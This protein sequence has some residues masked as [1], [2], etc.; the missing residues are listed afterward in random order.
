MTE[1][2]TSQADGSPTPCADRLYRSIYENDSD[3]ILL[4]DQTLRMMAA[5][6]SACLFLGYTEQELVGSPFEAV[7][8]RDSIPRAVGGL[9]AFPKTPGYLDLIR[10]DG[11]SFPAE[12]RIATFRNEGTDI[13][14]VMVRDITDRL[15]AEQELRESENRLRL[16][17]ENATDAICLLNADG[18]IRYH[19]PALERLSGYSAGELSGMVGFDLL[20]P[21]DRD[22]VVKVFTEALKK[23]GTTVSAN[24][25]IRQKDGT[26]RSVEG[27]GI[28]RIDDPAVR[29]FVL[30]VQDV[31]EKQKLEEILLHAQKMKAIGTLAGGVAHEINN[32]LMGIQ[33]YASLIL[34]DMNTADRHYDR[35]LH[36]QKQ[37]ESG[38]NLTQQLLGF[39]RSGRYEVKPTDINA[40][41]KKAAEVFG[42]SKREIRIHEHLATDLWPVEADRGQIEQ[43]LL[44]L[45]INAWQAMP[46]GGQLHLE[47]ANVTLDETSAKAHEISP[48]PYVRISVTDTGVGMDETTKARI[49]EPFFT[50][51]ELGRGKGLG[52]AVAYGIVRGH[53]GII[54]ASSEK[55]RGSVFSIYLPASDQLAVPENAV[56]T[57]GTQGG[58]TIL[59]VDDEPFIIDVT[60]D[61]LKSFGYEVLAAQSGA[62]AIQIYQE[63]AS[64]IGLV[65]LDMIMP[66]MGG[67]DVFERL[68]ITNPHV[69]VI[70]ASGYSISGH[71]QT[72]MER[73]C[74]AFLQKPFSMTEL[75][76]KVRE[77]L[78]QKSEQPAKADPSPRKK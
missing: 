5:N 41:V 23:P 64:S 1:K 57:K 38:A 2:T 31:T 73:G 27:F 59:I 10:K 77:V 68:K 16:L 69:K 7:V 13:T 37:V 26:S 30:N 3:G 36:I 46:S 15:Q 24:C 75:S 49:F 47:T 14:T 18:V 51:R 65:I 72:I 43:V 40:L 42:R 19:N 11:T 45:Y 52:L 33:G 48:G 66:D 55:G 25:R 6:R 71:A 17:F 9:F 56:S 39:A 61:I 29:G 74:S 63:Q 21:E 53:M 60:Q 44:N 22:R 58:E 8:A 70:L 76:G 67:G 34:M 4:L 32:V 54:T 12:I 62:E 50:T 28:N 35:L 78:D 20:H